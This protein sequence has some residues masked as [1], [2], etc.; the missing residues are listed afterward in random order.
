[1]KPLPILFLILF[2]LLPSCKKEK[3]N[4]DY[5][6]L[7]ALANQE[8]IYDS[9]ECQKHYTMNPAYV[10]SGAAQKFSSDFKQYK[11]IWIGDS[12]VAYAQTTN[13]ITQINAVGGDK[14]CDYNARFRK[15][16]K[17]KDPEF[18]I[19]QTVGG[20]DFLTQQ[21]DS[22][23]IDT[24]A[25]YSTRL[26]NQFPSSKLCWIKVHPT[27]NSYAN[28]AKDRLTPVFQTYTIADKWAVPD[29]C[30]STPPTQAELPD[31][32]HFSVATATCVKNQIQT[33]C[34]V[35]L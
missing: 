32:I 33:Q 13:E 10:I 8:G 29:N 16:I 34:G 23:I 11:N 25:D 24:F 21:G 12:S 17:T 15:S 7:L 3:A 5:L 18:I 31:G 30:F 1:M 2:L 27:A 22:I 6:L 20:N 4:N 26:R 28:S 35:S 19:T 14:L 9:V